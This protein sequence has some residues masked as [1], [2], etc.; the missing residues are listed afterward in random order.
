MPRMKPEHTKSDSSQT[1]RNR[2]RDPIVVAIA[3]FKL[4]KTAALIAAGIGLIEALKGRIDLSRFTN[5]LTPVRLR[6]ASVASFA[7]AALFLTEGLGLLMRKRWAPWLTVIATSSLIPFEIYEIVKETTVIR[8]GA[9]IVN[10]AV[11][12][13]LTWRIIHPRNSG[14]R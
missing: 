2:D 7:Y 8:I 6:W 1:R 9:L 10:I 14:L 12:L 5:V 3:I 13:Y 11:V 4:V